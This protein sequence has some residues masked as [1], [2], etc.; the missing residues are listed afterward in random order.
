[1]EKFETTT[2]IEVFV[3]PDYHFRVSAGNMIEV[4]YIE[5]G[6]EEHNVHIGFGSLNEM[7]AVAMAMLKVVKMQR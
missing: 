1:M 4:Q 7:E 2:S 5:H 3:D 6:H